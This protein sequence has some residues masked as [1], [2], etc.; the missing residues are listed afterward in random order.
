MNK[1]TALSGR[2]YYRNDCNNGTV[3]CWYDRSN[4]KETLILDA[5][6]R[7]Y[8]IWSKRNETLLNCGIKDRYGYISSDISNEI[9]NP[10]LSNQNIISQIATD[11]YLDSRLFPKDN[12]SSNHNTNVIIDKDSDSFDCSAGYCRSVDCD[13]PNIQ[14]LVRIFCDGPIIDSLDPTIIEYSDRSLT[15]TN[16]G[17]MSNG[18]IPF[19]WSSTEYDNYYAWIVSYTGLVG[20]VGKSDLVGGVIPIKELQ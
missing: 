13:L 3:M 10:Q 2:Q 8:K 9:T 1:V 5:K 6:F 19:A 15:V 17:W 12:N 11:Q 4:Y 7:S 16:N 18:T 14:T 20:T